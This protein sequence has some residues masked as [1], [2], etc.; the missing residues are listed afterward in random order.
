MALT[1]GSGPV[2]SDVRGESRRQG[3]VPAYDAAL[4]AAGMVTLVTSVVI[5]RVALMGAVGTGLA[6]AVLRR[7][8]IGPLGR[9]GVILAAVAAA[10]V[11]V[12]L[13]TM[14]VEIAPHVAERPVPLR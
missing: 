13:L 14:V 8:G 7:H 1:R 3:R 11:C 2:S 10:L 5:P 12:M 4:F 9:T 6:F